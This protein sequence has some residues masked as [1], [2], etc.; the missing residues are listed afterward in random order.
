MLSVQARAR[1]TVPW[2][3]VFAMPVLLAQHASAVSDGL[4]ARVWRLDVLACVTCLTP[5]F[6]P[7]P[8]APPGTCPNDCSGQGICRTLREVAAGA[9]S[10]TAIGNQG[11]SIIFAG[12]KEP[13]DYSLWDADKHQMCVCDAGFTG[14]DCSLRSCPRHGDPLTPQT[15]RWCGGE[16]CAHE[17]QSFRLSSAGETTYRF[18]FTDNRNVTSMAYA[19]VDTLANAPGIVPVDDRKTKIAGPTTN[20]GIIM[21]ALRSVPGGSMQL[22]EV[23]AVEDPDSQGSLQRTFEITFFGFSG[24]QYPL[25]IES[26]SGAGRVEDQPSTVTIGNIEDIECSGRG[27][28]DSSAGLCKCASYVSSLFGQITLTRT[29]RT[30]RPPPPSPRTA[31]PSLLLLSRYRLLRL[32]RCC[33]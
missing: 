12:V 5:S 11:G 29:N 30:P 16:E 7:H 20:A 31:R 6:Y 24:A 27:L 9:L 26:V 15:A 22:V 1:V 8:H 21:E 23:S 10:R 2:V 14:V 32:L 25:I 3:N 13:F 4:D 17:I 19:T 33:M 28:C 18:Q